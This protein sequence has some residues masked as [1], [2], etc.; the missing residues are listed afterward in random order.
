M[1]IK[2]AKSDGVI[3]V[4]EVFENETLY[5]I[6]KRVYKDNYFK[7]L[8]AKVNN[9]LK[10]LC[11]RDFEENDKIEFIDISHP[12]GHR[13]YVRT[14]SLIYVKACKDV[15]KDIDVSINYSLNKGLYTE[16]QHKH[17]VTARQLN[18][19]KQRMQEIIDAKNI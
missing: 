6:L 12:D 11:S 10:G 15:Y 2:L 4:I 7:Y 3:E 13:I 1:K 19:I 17:L 16:L 9:K 18:I 14:L 5:Q 8:G